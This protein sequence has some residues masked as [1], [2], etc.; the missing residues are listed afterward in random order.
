MASSSVYVYFLLLL[1][2]IFIGCTL[3][4]VPPS[5]SSPASPVPTPA[6]VPAPGPIATPK[7]VPAAE[8]VPLPNL[9]IPA[10]APA[11]VPAPSS[12]INGKTLPG[13][14]QEAYDRLHTY[15]SGPQIR[16]DFPDIELVYSDY[17]EGT[18]FPASILPFRYYFSPEANRTFNICN[19]DLT[20]FICKGKLGRL[21][22][23][24][25]IEDGR[26]EATPIYKSDSRLGYGQGYGDSYNYPS[27]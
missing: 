10:P 8:P 18:G 20:V 2:F 19:I 23:Q 24:S 25:D 12:T 9:S 16:T 3:S 27:R 7:P 14:L 22:T 11:P 5:T 1:T 26:C 6:I 4:P 17:A 15:G 21:I 13:R